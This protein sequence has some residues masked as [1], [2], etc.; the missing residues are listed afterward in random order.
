MTNEYTVA[1]WMRLFSFTLLLYFISCQAQPGVAVVADGKPV[2]YRQTDTSIRFQGYEVRIQTPADSVR[3]D[4]LLL[5][6]WDFSNRKWCDSTDVCKTALAKGFRVIAPQMH[7]SVYATVYTNKT[8]PDLKQNPTLQWLDSMIDFLQLSRG[9][10]K[11]KRYVLGLSTGGRGVALICERKTGFFHAAAALS[12]DYNQLSMPQDNLM[13]LVYG[14]SMSEVGQKIW[15]SVDNPQMNCQNMKTP[16][17]LGHG[18][19]DRIVPV[20]QTTE[21]AMALNQKHPR[22]DVKLHIDQTAAHNFKYWRSELPAIWEFF[23][24]H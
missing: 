1:N 20:R 2:K 6:G 14:S 4:L 11:D 19:L 21:F 18:M 8:R 3:G 7:R 5:P 23:G 9:Y 12:G 22:L 15:S 13:T 17:Y 10:F 16:I 24:K